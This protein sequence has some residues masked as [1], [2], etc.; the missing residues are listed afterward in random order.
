MA[1]PLLLTLFVILSVP[2]ASA[3]SNITAT[4]V[5]STKTTIN[6]NISAAVNSPIPTTAKSKKRI[7][8]HSI[9]PHELDALLRV[10][11]Y[12]GYPLFSNAID[13]SDVRFQIL[14]GHATPAFTIFAP[15]DRFLY[16]LDMASDADAYVAAL[17]YHVIPSCRLTI[18]EIRNLTSPYLETLLPHYSILVGKSESDYDFVTVDGVR[19]SDPN[20]YLG[21]RFAVHGLDGILLTGFNMYEDTLADMGK[22]FFAPEK[23]EHFRPKSS[24]KSAAAALPEA[25]IGGFPRVKRKQRKLQSLGLEE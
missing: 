16:T 24:R 15:R 1:N 17:R 14:T 5:N 13:T 6:S 21:S 3:K 19:I 20:L 11:R 22:G 9:S 2:A 7:T 12:S 18:A 8:K 25:K 10:L 4:A 23:V